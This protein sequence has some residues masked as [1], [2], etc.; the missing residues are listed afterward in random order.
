M[1]RRY[2]LILLKI[3]EDAALARRSRTIDA[4][5][6][7]DS[8]GWFSSRASLLLKRSLRTAEDVTMAMASRGFTG[9]LKTNSA[10]R[11]KGWDLVWIGCASFIFFLSFGL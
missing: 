10:G 11:L 3:A 9:R 6:V 2:L 5:A 8:R 7:K 1:T 4:A